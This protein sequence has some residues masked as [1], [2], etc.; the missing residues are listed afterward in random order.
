M[1]LARVKETTFSSNRSIDPKLVMAAI[2]QADPEPETLDEKAVQIAVRK[3]LNLVN[4][5]GYSVEQPLN[6]VSPRGGGFHLLRNALNVMHS[7]EA[8]YRGHMCEV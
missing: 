1:N 8:W 4:E 2:L 7:K 6:T 3:V 5:N